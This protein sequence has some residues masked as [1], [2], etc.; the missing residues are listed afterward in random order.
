MPQASGTVS[1]FDAGWL[2]LREPADHAARDPGLLAR[3][4]AVAGR[5]EAPV[6]VDLGCGTGSGMRA[7]AP[8]LPP[9]ACWRLVDH[10]RRLLDEAR[11]RAGAGPG[12]TF[13]EAGLADLDALPLEGAAL[14]TASALF[15]LVSE[16]WL[17]AFADRL[18][19]LRIPLYAALTYDGTVRWTPRHPLDDA[20]A[21]A[22]GRH[23]RTDKGLGPA[24]GPGAPARMKD[25]LEERGFACR[26]A[27]SPWR[28]GPGEALLQAE[29]ARGFALAAA[30]LGTPETGR[31]PGWLGFRTAAAGSGRATVGHLDLLAEPA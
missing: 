6:V 13:H 2:D 1:G 17:A 31:I 26:L 8:Y 24:L 5:R 22:L 29:L 9:G 19:A 28:L 15:D 4:A 21:A 7:F 20:M 11:R 12:P 3:A 18:A 27:A 14:V 25:I 30:E 23:Q 10:D 16:N